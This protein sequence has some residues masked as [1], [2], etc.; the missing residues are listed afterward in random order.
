MDVDSGKILFDKDKDHPVSVASMTKM[1]AQMIIL[2]E[3]EK[4]HIKWTDV[5]TVSKNASEMGGSQIYL[6]E[7]EKMSVLDLMKG[8]SVAS[9]N[10]ATL[11]MAE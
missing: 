6:E 5:V 1:V 4:K 2:E 9:A 3:V 10:D 7:N 11:A 8:I